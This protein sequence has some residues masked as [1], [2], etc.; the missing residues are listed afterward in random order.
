MELGEF[1]DLTLDFVPL[2]FVSDRHAVRHFVRSKDFELL[3]QGVVY[4]LRRAQF[5]SGK[6]LHDERLQSRDWGPDTRWRR[7]VAS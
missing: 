5:D 3:A 2:A 6:G 4:V 1:E 7:H